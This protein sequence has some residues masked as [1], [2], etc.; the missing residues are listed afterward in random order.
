MFDE[1]VNVI[2]NNSRKAQIEG[3]SNRAPQT[4]A[5]FTMYLIVMLSTKIVKEEDRISAE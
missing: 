2:M 3:L 4:Q 5:A 1:E